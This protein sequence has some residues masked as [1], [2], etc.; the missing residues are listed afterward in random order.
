MAE[1]ETPDSHLER[2]QGGG[3]T[4]VPMWQRLTQSVVT[5]SCST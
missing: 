2:I 4:Q 3:E 5:G 1:D